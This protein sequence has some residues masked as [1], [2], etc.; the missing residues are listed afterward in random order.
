[1]FTKLK[2]YAPVLA[3]I[4]MGLGLLFRPGDLFDALVAQWPI[5]GPWLPVTGVLLLGYFGVAVSIRWAADIWNV[6][7][8][9]V[10]G[11]REQ[12]LASID[13]LRS[14]LPGGMY[15]WAGNPE[16]RSALAKADVIARDLIGRGIL[17]ERMNNRHDAR[18]NQAYL[19]R[20]RKHVSRHGARYARKNRIG[21]I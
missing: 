10:E 16:N 12:V 18:F 17:D 6:V 11:R 14:N 3:C 4:L 9:K 5:V 2:E 13:D 15:N 21:D 8:A 7:R 20:L 1:M 19:A